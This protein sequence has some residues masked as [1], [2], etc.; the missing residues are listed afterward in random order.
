ML[1]ASN[2]NITRTTHILGICVGAFIMRKV[3]VCEL[4]HDGA[5]CVVLVF[6]VVVGCWLGWASARSRRRTEETVR[7]D[8]FRLLLYYTHTHIYTR[9]TRTFFYLYLHIWYYILNNA[10][11]DGYLCVSVMMMLWYFIYTYVE[12]FVFC[13]SCLLELVKWMFHHSSKVMNK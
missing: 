12:I 9:F 2:L 5:L 8:S 7:I 11:W 10:R 1:N 6:A 3:A 4:L 13:S